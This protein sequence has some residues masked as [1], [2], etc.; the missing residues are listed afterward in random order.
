MVATSATDL[1]TL[2][3]LCPAL[4]GAASV[5]Y[6]HEN[7][8]A[9]PWRESAR[10]NALHLQLQQIFGALSAD[11][12]LFNSAF[13]QASFLEGARSL[14]ER[15]PDGVPAD[16]LAR[17]E[18]KSAVVP[19]GIDP[20]CFAL[21]PKT[22]SCGDELHL[23]WNHRWEYDKAPERVFAAIELLAEDPDFA[24]R[25]RLHVV[26]QRFR[27]SPAV[28]ERITHTLRDHL[29]TLGH[30]RA[31]QDY[32]ELLER[33]DVVLSA[34]LHEF[35]GLSVLEAMAAGCAVVAPDRLAYKEYVPLRWRYRSSEEDAQAEVK[36]IAQALRELMTQKTDPSA[37]AR[38]AASPYHWDV[39]E[40]QWRALLDDL[41]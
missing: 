17:L 22:R 34:A 27:K 31:R 36:A 8:F 11:R 1:V 40:A 14:L 23:L 41:C 15:M 37:L 30:L 3:G 10:A 28:F 4:H 16:T 7:Q 9:Y 35:Q 25:L 6:F 32:L 29:V 20:A 33:S 26:G 13:N 2:K 12:V 38:A 24:P 5:L 39:V 21:S 19:V 18:Q